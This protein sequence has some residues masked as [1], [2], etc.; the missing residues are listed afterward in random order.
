MPGT[1]T[2]LGREQVALAA[3]KLAAKGIAYKA[4]VT[5]DLRRAMDSA[6]IIAT[7]LQLPV[8]PMRELRERDWG[9]YTGMTIHEAVRRYKIRGKW[10]FPTDDAETDER[11]L[12][13]ARHALLMLGQM[14]GPDDDIIVVTHGQFARNIIAARLH[15]SYHEVV[16]MVNAE[17]RE[18]HI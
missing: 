4:I 7:R 15:C 11:I 2:A 6:N 3:D 18:L 16:P 1:L 8:V 10:K 14:Y 9:I 5:S 12:N 17:I 13:R